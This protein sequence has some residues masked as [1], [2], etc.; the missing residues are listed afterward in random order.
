M[1]SMG[2]FQGPEMPMRAPTEPK[3]GLPLR[4]GA[5]A[6]TVGDR[7]DDS[8]GSLGHTVQELAPCMI[9]ALHI[10]DSYWVFLL[11]KVVISFILLYFFTSL[12]P[13]VVYAQSE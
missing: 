7:G 3:R 12:K 4:A 2:T 6:C 11:P 13:A 8:L 10:T 9:E 1:L 5:V